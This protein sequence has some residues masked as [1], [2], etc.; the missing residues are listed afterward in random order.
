MGAAAEHWYAT[1]N[2]KGVTPKGVPCEFT[3][4]EIVEG[5]ENWPTFHSLKNI[6]W[7]TP[8]K[9]NDGNISREKKSVA[10]K[11]QAKVESPTEQ[12]KPKEVKTKQPQA[13]K[14]K[15]RVEK[16]SPDATTVDAPVYFKCEICGRDD[17]TS[18]RAM[19][20]HQRYCRQKNK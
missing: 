9:P 8:E 12:A 13:K 16:K 5:V 10:P 2:F 7:I 14:T 4:G 19:K 20:V 15:A 11:S 6:S 1:R 17:F 3:R 18:S